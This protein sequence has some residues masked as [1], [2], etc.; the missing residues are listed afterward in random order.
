MPNCAILWE[1]NIVGVY[2]FNSWLEFFCDELVVCIVLVTF[3]Y[4]SIPRFHTYCCWFT[5]SMYFPLVAFDFVA[6]VFSISFLFTVFVFVAFAYCFHVKWYWIVSICLI[7]SWNCTELCFKAWLT[8]FSR[9]VMNHLRNNSLW[10]DL[11]KIDD[12]WGRR[13]LVV[14]VMAY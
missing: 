1:R 3:A 2:H 6:F 10:S 11:L 4:L 5:C 14:S 13:S 9:S 7:I 12:H 8:I